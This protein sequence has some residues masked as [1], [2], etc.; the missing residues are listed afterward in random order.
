MSD[1]THNR[2]VTIPVPD[3]GETIEVV[4]DGLYMLIELDD[5]AAEAAPVED[6]PD[7]FNEVIGYTV[8]DVDAPSAVVT[9]AAAIW[10]RAERTRVESHTLCDQSGKRRVRRRRRDLPIEHVTCKQCRRRLESEGVL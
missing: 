2:T 6:V 1:P 3:P 8:V 4:V 10:Q 9:H 7:G 5:K